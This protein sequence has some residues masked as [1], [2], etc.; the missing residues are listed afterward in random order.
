MEGEARM[1]DERR[2][3]VIEKRKLTGRDRIVW[4]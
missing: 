3:R 2:I 4:I 1:N